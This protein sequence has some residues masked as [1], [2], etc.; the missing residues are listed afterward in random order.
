MGLGYDFFGITMN[1]IKALINDKFISSELTGIEKVAKSW[2]KLLE[3]KIFASIPL[4]MD[5]VNKLHK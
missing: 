5:C 1:R 3:M 2:S 4:C